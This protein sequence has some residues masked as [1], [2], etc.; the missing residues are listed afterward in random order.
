M[1]LRLVLGMSKSQR[2]DLSSERNDRL[3]I[4]KLKEIIR[5]QRKEIARLEKELNRR[6]DVSE[7]YR[8]LLEEEQA[9]TVAAKPKPSSTCPECG[10]ATFEVPIG[11]ALLIRCTDRKCKFRKRTGNQ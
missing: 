9:R 3:T 6:Q 5:D 2:Q 1:E 11:Q 4:Q 10:A 8:D 7:N